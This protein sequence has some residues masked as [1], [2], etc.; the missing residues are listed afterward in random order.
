MTDWPFSEPPDMVVFA[1]R[2]IAEG[3]RPV[4]IFGRYPDGSYCAY[5]GDE[6]VDAERE[7]ACVC[8]S[9]I[10]EIEPAVRELADIQLG[11]WAVRETASSPWV[12]EQIPSEEL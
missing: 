9:H 2:T 1:H 12:R 8:L 6:V 10:V 11:W 3:E 5:T 7:I 4:M